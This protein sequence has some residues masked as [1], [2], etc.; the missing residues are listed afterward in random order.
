VRAF[1]RPKID[2]DYFSAIIAQAM[3]PAFEIGQF[4]V[5]DE[6]ID[7][8]IFHGLQRLREAPLWGQTL[9]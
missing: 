9:A 6:M 3:T 4:K 2:D 8:H 7:I 5:G 1:T